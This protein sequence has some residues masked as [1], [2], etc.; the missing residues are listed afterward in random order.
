MFRLTVSKTAFLSSFPRIR[1]DVPSLRQSCSLGLAFSPHTRG[2]SERFRLVKIND[3]VFPAY[4]GMFL[5]PVNSKCLWNSFPRIRGDVPR[6]NISPT[7]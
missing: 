6:E 4:A 2:C 3:L 7:D 5:E 1:G